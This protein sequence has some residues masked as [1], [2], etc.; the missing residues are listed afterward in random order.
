[1][2]QASDVLQMLPDQVR[3]EVALHVYKETIDASSF[4]RDKSTAFISDLVLNFRPVHYKAGSYISTGQKF[5]TNWY[6]LKHGCVS[7]Q[8]KLRRTFLKFVPNCTIGEIAYFT[9]YKPLY[10]FK[11]VCLTDCDLYKVP[12]TTLTDL[13]VKYP[14]ELKDME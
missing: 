13:K 2:A 1:M 6:L 5:M 4:F 14:R 9:K 8:V 10:D 11:L 3:D 12:L 7:A